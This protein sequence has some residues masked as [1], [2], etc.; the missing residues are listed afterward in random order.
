M[1]ETVVTIGNFINTN[2]SAMNKAESA[3]SRFKA[4]HSKFVKAMMEGD[5]APEMRGATVKQLKESFKGWIDNNT[6]HIKIN[7]GGIVASY[8][9]NKEAILDF[10]TD[11]K[12]AEMLKFSK[13]TEGIVS[14]KEMAALEKALVTYRE[15]CLP[16]IVKEAA[17]KLLL[18]TPNK[19]ERVKIIEEQ[20]KVIVDNESKAQKELEEKEA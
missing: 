8:D 15:H 2:W 5:F 16:Y 18:I 10:Q 7:S 13:G 12:R 20:T 6:D 4:K 1:S 9:A 14:E 17:A 19:K 3:K 11:I